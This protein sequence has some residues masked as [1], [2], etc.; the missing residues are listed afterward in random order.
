MPR[1]CFYLNSLDWSISSK[2]VAWLVLL[3][4]WFTEIP[5]I[6]ANSV[7][8]DQTPRLRRLIWIYAV[9]QCPILWDTRHKWVKLFFPADLTRYMCKQSRS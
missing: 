7:D 9:C 8:P 2:R 4:R 5:V 3:L 6:N 1:G